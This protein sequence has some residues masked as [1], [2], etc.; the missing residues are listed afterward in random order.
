MDQLN[1]GDKVKVITSGSHYQGATGV[2]DSVTSKQWLR[3]VFTDEGLREAAKP[4][5]VMH[6]SGKSIPFIYR[7]LER[8]P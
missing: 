8:V 2:I 6:S 5:R 3:V 4:E 1:V 7:E